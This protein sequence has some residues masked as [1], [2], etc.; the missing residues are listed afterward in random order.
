MDSAGT[1]LIHAS[2]VGG[3]GDDLGWG[4]ALDGDGSIYVAGE[5]ISWEDSF[6]VTAG[7][8]LTFNGVRDAF[9]AKI[10][11]SVPIISSGGT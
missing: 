5:T 8:D 1:S 6:P 3:S 7:P 9:V 2:Y 10:D 11:I 4:I